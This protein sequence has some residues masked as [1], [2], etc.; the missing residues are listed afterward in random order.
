MNTSRHRGSFLVL[1]WGTLLSTLLPGCQSS[2]HAE[3]SAPVAER[4]PFD[5]VSEHGTR[6]DDDYWLRDDTRTDEDMLQ[7]LADENRYMQSQL[8][9][10]AGLRKTLN[11]EL[12]QRL[13]QDDSTPP[14]LN[15]GESVLVIRGW[16]MAKTRLVAGSTRFGLRI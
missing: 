7:Y 15:R 9:P 10:V 11:E 12:I 8:E 6:T 14:V 16:L 4:R 1:A 3:Q 5:V 13:I 2:P